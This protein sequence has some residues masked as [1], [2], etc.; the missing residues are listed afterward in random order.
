MINKYLCIVRNF[1]RDKVT[2]AYQNDD[3]WTCLYDW[4]QNILLHVSYLELYNCTELPPE[5]VDK[6]RW[7][8]LPE[9]RLFSETMKP[10][11]ERKKMYD[12]ITDVKKRFEKEQTKYPLE[13]VKNIIQN[14][15]YMMPSQKSRRINWEAFEADVRALIADE[16]VYLNLSFKDP[17]SMVYMDMKHSYTLPEPNNILSIYMYEPVTMTSDTRNEIENSII[18]YVRDK[19]PEYHISDA[20]IIFYD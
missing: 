20:Q 16:F 15:L 2:N 13:S 14:L 10:D 17:T 7:Y 12:A 6:Y 4:M 8:I 5:D 9:S 11:S 1:I 18:S 19:Y 3:G